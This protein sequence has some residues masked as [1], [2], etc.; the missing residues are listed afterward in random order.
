MSLTQSVFEFEQGHAVQ[1]RPER[2]AGVDEAGRGPLAGAVYAAAVILPKHYDL[3]G[4]TD[5]KKLTERRREQLFDAIQQQSVA[6]AIHAV[7]AA[8]IDA[9]N[10]FQA[11]MHAMK[12]AAEALETVPEFVYVD[13]NRCPEWS[14][15]SAA[16][17]KGDSR[18]GCIAAASV[19][20][21]VARDREMLALDAQ[22]PAYGFA[23]HKGYPTTVHLAALIE[24]GPCPAHRSSYAP[25]AR[26]IERFQNQK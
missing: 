2:T 18:L 5:S 6:Y 10:I 1:H 20:A 24:H 17:V 14:Y 26:A 16:L 22:Y 7:S 8:D 15:P 23:R 4:L 13:G 3:P 25:V 12:S 19:L 21:K 9:M 11:T